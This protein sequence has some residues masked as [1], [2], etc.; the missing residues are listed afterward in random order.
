MSSISVPPDSTGMDIAL[1]DIARR[2][3]LATGSAL[4]T[5]YPRS[6]ASLLERERAH[7]ALGREIADLLIARDILLAHR[8]EAL[9]KA[10][11]AASRVRVRAS[12]GCDKIQ[13]GG[14]QPVHLTL[15]GGT[16]LRFYTRYL[17]P[18]L[19]GRVGRPRGVGKRGAAG[20]GAYP[21]LEQLGIVDRVTPL[22][23]SIVATQTVLCGSLDEAR[24]Q[25]ETMGLDLHTST[26]TRIA[27]GTGLTAINLRDTALDE[28]RQQP[29]PTTSVLAGKRLRLSVD[30]GR[31]RIRHTEHGRGIRPGK[32]GRRPFELKWHEPRVITLDVVDADGDTD[33]HWRPVYEVTL[34]QADDVF[35]LMTGVLR[36]VGAHLA[37]EVVFVSDGATWIWNRL[38]QLRADAGIEKERFSAILDYFHATEYITGAL[39]ECKNL[40]DAERDSMFR[41]MKGQLLEADGATRVVARLRGLAR[42]R[43]AGAI[44][45]KIAYFEAHTDHTGY[46]AHRAAK[47]PIGSGV[48]ES[49]VRRLINLRFKSASMCWH[50]DHVAPLLYL[51][52]II[53]AGRW[54]DFMT[55]MLDGRHWLQA[56]GLGLEADREAA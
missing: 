30:G 51:R 39:A 31:V 22:T 42:G 14:W 55:A 34:G 10:A 25:L 12:S 9:V 46:A 5:A 24:S 48:V 29:L 17:R 53:K 41:E 7:E 21:I 19:K 33:R 18:S 20:A 1:A 43:R 3:A 13:D 44:L 40:T 15:P 49:A 38:D 27:V 2:L 54:E 50:E 28:A 6:G 45:K 37:A 8:D 36:R 16:D 4:D 52:A 47:R 26:L 23:R 32:N 35:A 56:G 11:C